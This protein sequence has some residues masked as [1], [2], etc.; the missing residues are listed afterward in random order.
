MSLDNGLKFDQIRAYLSYYLKS[1]RG[2]QILEFLKW[3]FWFFLPAVTFLQLSTAI[4]I[5]W[6]WM[7]SACRF[8]VA[9]GY[10]TASDRIIG[11]SSQGR[12]RK[13]EL[14]T[15]ESVTGPMCLIFSFW[16]T[17]NRCGGRLRRSL[18]D[19]FKYHERKRTGIISGRWIFTYYYRTLFKSGVVRRNHA[20][21]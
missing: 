19:Y 14:K 11:W 16:R 13:M 7:L 12:F 15:L 10:Q 18:C 5:L 21:N 20:R 9:F 4:C 2:P 1:S 3:R 6:N 8:R 17:F